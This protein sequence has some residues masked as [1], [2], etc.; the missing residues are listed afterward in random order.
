[1][2]KGGFENYIIERIQNFS[3]NDDAKSKSSLPI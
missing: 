1:M 3:E 2:S